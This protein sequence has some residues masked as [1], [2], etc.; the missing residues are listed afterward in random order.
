MTVHC[1]TAA[2]IRAGF[3]PPPIPGMIADQQKSVVSTG[4]ARAAGTVGRPGRELHRLLAAR[5]GRTR[6]LAGPGRLASPTRAARSDEQP[7]GRLAELQPVRPTRFSSATVAAPLAGCRDGSGHAVSLRP[8]YPRRDG[9]TARPVPGLLDLA[10]PE[11]GLSARLVSR[12][13]TPTTQPVAALSPLVMTGFLL[14]LRS[15]TCI[16]DLRDR[17][18]DSHA[19]QLR[20]RVAPSWPRLSAPPA[21]LLCRR[22]RRAALQGPTVS[23]HRP[24]ALGRARRAR[25]QQA[26]R[27]SGEIIA[28]YEASRARG[29]VGSRVAFW[30][31]LYLP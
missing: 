17:R 3:A 29:W 5:V 6:D 19:K 16:G 8:R 28:K 23:G 2:P 25:D 27:L 21:R 30:D 15:T 1:G 31:V 14:G 9:R 18:L 22:V 7:V 4:G 13:L 10:Q 12:R 20:N 11:R 24:S 26:C